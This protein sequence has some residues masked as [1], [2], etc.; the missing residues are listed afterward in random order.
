MSLPAQLLVKEHAYWMAVPKLVRV[1]AGGRTHCMSRYH[2]EWNLPRPESF[3]HAL[4]RS[5]RSR[6]LAALVLP[7]CKQYCI[8]L[9]WCCGGSRSR[10]PNTYM[11]IMTRGS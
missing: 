3:R 6:V 1:A 10:R 5:L 8:A 11:S 7:Q 2:A 4:Q 9:S